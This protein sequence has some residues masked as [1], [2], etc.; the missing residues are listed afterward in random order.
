MNRTEAMHIE[1]L[2]QAV[3][4]RFSAGTVSKWIKEKTYLR[5]ERVSFKGREYQQRILDDESQEVCVKKPSQVGISEMSVRM[6]LALANIVPYYTLAYTLPTAGFASVFAKT[7][8]DPVIAECETAKEA[9]D[10]ILNNSEVKAFGSSYIYFRGCAAG[11]AAISIPVDHVIHDEIDFSDQEV[12]SQY[13]SRLTA[14][15]YKRKTKLSTPTIPDYG[16]SKEFKN[17]RRFF[18]LVKCDHCNHTFQPDYYKHVK[19]PGFDRHLDE[20]KKNHLPHIQWE[21]AALLCPKCGKVPDLT[22]K[23]REWVQENPGENHVAAGYQVTPWD[24]PGIV[25][26]ASLVKTSTNY[27]R[28]QDFRNFGLGLEMDD[29]EASLA[30]EEMNALFVQGE[31]YSPM[32]VMGLDLGLTCHLM[33][34][35]VGLDGSLLVVHAERIPVGDLRRRVPELS[36]RWNCSV[37]VSDALPYTETVIVMQANMPNLYGAV[38]VRSKNLELFNIKQQDDNERTGKEL[39]RQLNVNRDLALDAYMDAIRSGMIAFKSMPE[40]AEIV[41]HHTDMRRVKIFDDAK[42]MRFTWQKSATGNDHY[43]FAGLYTY[44]ASRLKGT[45]HVTSLSSFAMRSIHVPEK[46]LTTAEDFFG[47]RPVRL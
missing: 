31:G 37:Q 41:D 9:L 17:S 8:L 18:N 26:A 28:V 27:V 25:T 19:V 44:I 2:R 16:I 32:R 47:P 33:I 24:A 10:P 40:Q 23:H 12:L 35:E 39:I 20:I 6:A 38:F 4:E 3:L 11:N 42:E 13:E 14:S 29:V 15:P 30:K 43:H 34:A 21:K 5:G 7:R 46:V 1:R 36:L 22:P 45:A